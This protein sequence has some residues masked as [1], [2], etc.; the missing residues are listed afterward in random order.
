MEKS[1]TLLIFIVVALV[2]AF[3]VIMMI[4]AITGDSQNLFTQ[5]VDKFRDLLNLK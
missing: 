2:G 5:T 3:I 1:I 4:S